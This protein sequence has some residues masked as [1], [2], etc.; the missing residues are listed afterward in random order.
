MSENIYSDEGSVFPD[1]YASKNATPQPMH[2]EI[3]SN[4]AGE[5]YGPHLHFGDGMAYAHHNPLMER[6]RYPLE[7]LATEIHGTAA[8]K[9]FWSAPEMMDKYA[10]KLAL[11]HSEVT[12][13]LEALRK[14]QGEDKVT[15]EFAD[16]IIRLLDLFDVLADSGEAAPNLDQVIKEKMEANEQR[17]PK[18]GHRWG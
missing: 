12:E 14:R 6:D 5:S 1:D 11:V 8:A 18:H 17:P 15:E 2:V 4:R 9:G 13:I 3:K 16:V 10:A 7:N